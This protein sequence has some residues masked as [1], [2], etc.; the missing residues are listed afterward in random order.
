MTPSWQ[1]ERESERDTKLVRVRVVGVRSQHR[2]LGRSWRQP[3]SAATAL[4][5]TLTLPT[6]PP[7]L[8][9]S[10]SARVK[11]STFTTFAVAS[12]GTL[13]FVLVLWVFFLCVFCVS[14]TCCPH[15]QFVL[16]KMAIV[17]ESARS[18]ATPPYR[19]CLH[20]CQLPTTF[21]WHSQRATVATLAACRSFNQNCFVLL[22]PSLSLSH[23]YT[24]HELFSWNCQ[25]KFWRTFHGAWVR[26]GKG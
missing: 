13:S 21:G 3:G 10:C 11:I 20:P 5:L 19:F 6:V 26:E 1:R 24:L 23:T 4:A 15:P 18:T 2:V 17:R 14:R 12:R 8:F 16:S 9:H 22:S 7:S 25:I